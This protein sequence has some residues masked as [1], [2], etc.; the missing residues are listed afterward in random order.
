MS[1]EMSAIGS[2]RLAI[3]IGGTFTDLAAVDRRT[4]RL[5]LAK[6]DSTP[7]RFEAGVLRALERSGLDPTGV[8]AFVHGTT[9]VVNAVT[10]R[11][12]AATALVTTRGFRDVLEIGRANRPDLYNLS[13]AK[14]RPFVRRRHR[15]E[16]T[17]RM[18]H[19]GEV[20]VPLVE[21]EIEP[22]AQRLREDEIEAVAVCFLHPWANPEHERR[23]GELLGKLL[24]GVEIVASHEVSGEWREYERSSTVVLSAFVKPVVS[25]YLASLRDEL[26][27]AGVGGPLYA[28]RSSGGVSSFER[29]AAAPIALLESGTVAGVR[30]AAELG[31]RLGV[32]DV[33]ALDIGGTT[34]KTSAIRG[35]RVR[36]ETLHQVERTPSFAGYPV[37]TPVVE[38]VEIGA[39]GG[40]IAWVDEAGG[41]HVGPRSAGAEPGPA[42]YARGGTEPTVTD[43]NLV[44]GRLDPDYFLGGTMRLD[45]GGAAAA[46]ERL[47]RR[48]GVDVA[49]AARGVLRYAV[50]QMANALRLVTLRRG[51][52]PRD[53][54]FV[55]FGGA[56][57]LH[58]ALLARELGIG[59]TVIPPA[60]G[61]FSAFGMLL[62]DFRSDAV[63]THVGPLV[64]RPIAVV[65]DLLEREA[66]GELE[67]EAGER[68]VER[69]AHLRYVGQEHT[70]EVPLGPG[71]VD[72]LLLERLRGDFDRSSEEHY[73]FS[74]PDSPV[75]VVALR[76]S[77]S[78]SAGEV[79]WAGEPPSGEVSLAPREVDF[80][81]H[82]GRL[83]AEVL[84]RSVLDGR[85]AI[86]G[87]CIVEEPAT[88][89]LVL[90]GQRV[91]LDE[92]GDL[93]IEETA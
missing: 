74:L 42:C 30:A 58:A 64:P 53:F 11:R 85:A 12:G 16:V 36:I 41:L 81:Q 38:I 34:A 32:E 89:T 51:H 35:G 65:V 71:D 67:E 15:F 23:A 44:A 50:A 4:G 90:P 77:V 10:E 76:V 25:R 29:A 52:D 66:A 14:P 33:L 49:T 13:Y 68:R 46:L 37:Q 21:E 78:A 55:A 54:T 88:T 60:P 69:F 92:L 22:I 45:G 18:S 19:R 47:G 61:H 75:E 43:A 7:G 20:L 39:G 91:R 3:D 8:A 62:A 28:M 57:P 17:E 79:G 6:A 40:S 56:G 31:R 5:V 26:R 48:L 80:D 86:E 73:A 83:A 59:R 72:A 82:G 63:R 9:V 93:V 1:S 27:A 2:V 70:L 84:E 87:P 24:P